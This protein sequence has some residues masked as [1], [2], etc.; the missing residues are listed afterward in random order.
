MPGY[1]NDERRTGNIAKKG[2]L[3]APHGVFAERFPYRNN[4]K[5]FYI[6]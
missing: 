4:F 1:K 2:K 3:L 6:L 5:I